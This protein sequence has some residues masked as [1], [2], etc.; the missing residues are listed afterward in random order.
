MNGSEQKEGIIPVIV[1]ADFVCP[2]SYM[3][4]DHIDRLAEE[5]DVEPLWKPHWL[6]PEVPP[7]GQPRENGEGSERKGAMR[8]W[9]K[10]LSPEKAASLRPLNKLQ[11]SLLAFQALTYAEERGKALPFK[12]AVFDALWAEGKDIGEVATL[13]EA[14]ETTGLDAEEIGRVLHEGT[15][16]ER[17]METVDKVRRMGV[18]RT[19]TIVL[20][21]TMIPGYHYYEVFQTILEKQDVFPKTKNVEG[22]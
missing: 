21:R 13:Q 20:G 4:Q 10:E 8:E 15:Y 18:T 22:Q 19:P 14:A 9:M 2:W 17:T 11:Y 12:T 7:E 5:Y 3:V 6:H 1:F 16:L